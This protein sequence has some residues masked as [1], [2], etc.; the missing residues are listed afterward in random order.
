MK[1]LIYLRVSTEEQGEF[2]VSLSAQRAKLLAYAAL[3]DHAVVEVIEEDQSAKNL[4][5]PEFRRALAMLRSGAADGL[6]VAKLDRLTRNLGD[7][8]HLIDNYFGVKAGKTLVSMGESI[9]TTTAV[10]RMMLNMIVTIAAWEREVIGER[11]RDALQHKRS[12]GERVGA[13][14]FGYDLAP[15]GVRLVPNAAEQRVLGLTRT[16]RDG[17]MSLRQIAAEL[18]RQNLPTKKGGSRWT[19]ATVQ[20]I[21]ARKTAP[22]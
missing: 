19:H 1:I 21:L 2:G 9:D 17:G 11:T 13:I 10:G 7:W 4:N 22:A 5:R 16:L 18:S 12:R 15:D 6:L 14:P 3:Y 20:R 8:Q